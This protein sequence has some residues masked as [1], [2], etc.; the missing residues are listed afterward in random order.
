M[1]SQSTRRQRKHFCNF[2]KV[3]RRCYHKIL[4]LKNKTKNEISRAAILNFAGELMLRCVCI[5]AKPKFFNHFVVE[6]KKNPKKKT[7][8][9][10]PL[11]F[12]KFNICDTQK[13]ES[14]FKIIYWYHKVSCTASH[15]QLSLRS[16]KIRCCFTC[17]FNQR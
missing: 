2:F 5:F 10:M 17:T 1:N 4:L 6:P 16:H 12:I 9:L 14:Y 7:N 13:R 3:V 15:R 8:N 11:K